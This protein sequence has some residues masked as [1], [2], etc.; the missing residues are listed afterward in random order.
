MQAGG[1]YELVPEN[2]NSFVNSLDV[3]N[4]EGFEDTQSS[5]CV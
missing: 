3:D 1:D 2:S 5:D 4:E